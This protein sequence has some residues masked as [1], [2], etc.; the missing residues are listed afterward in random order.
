MAE[1]REEALL[2]K[3]A[4]H[5]HGSDSSSTDSGDERSSGPS[6]VAAAAE[7]ANAKI[8]RLFGREKPLHTVLGGG[9]RMYTVCSPLMPFL[10]VWICLNQ[11]LFAHRFVSD[12]IYVF[13]VRSKFLIAPLVPNSYRCFFTIP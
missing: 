7:V 6:A 11:Y 9:K 1:H 12:L 3:I 13:F 8:Y 2:E 5:F 10:F 4:D